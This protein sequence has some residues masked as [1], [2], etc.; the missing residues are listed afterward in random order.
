[1]SREE[2]ME[3]RLF[4]QRNPSTE[5]WYLYMDGA[6]QLIEGFVSGNVLFY[7]VNAEG[8]PVNRMA[9]FDSMEEC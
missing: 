6:L 5:S 1:M 3:T 7:G 9:H 2:A 8:V 4:W